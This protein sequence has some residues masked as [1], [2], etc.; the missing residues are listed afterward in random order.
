MRKRPLETWQSK[1]F[2]FSIQRT[3]TN[4]RMIQMELNQCCK[5]ISAIIAIILAIERTPDEH[6]VVYKAC[7]LI[8][9]NET[10]GVSTS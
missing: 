10:T 1:F 2:R 3:N 6:L 7:R 8:P 4:F 9:L 5:E